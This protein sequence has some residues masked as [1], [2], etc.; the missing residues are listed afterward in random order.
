MGDEKLPS[1][2]HRT[3]SEIL[4]R[5]VGTKYRGNLEGLKHH[6]YLI[7]QKTFVAY[8]DK[9]LTENSYKALWLKAERFEAWA[10]QVGRQLRVEGWTNE[11]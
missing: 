1:E 5:L 6:Q 10:N 2:D 3:A 8:S 9:K 4:Q 7:S 11:E